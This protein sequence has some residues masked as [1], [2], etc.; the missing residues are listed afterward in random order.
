[1][2]FSPGSVRA[3]NRTLSEP[4][5]TYK[6]PIFVTQMMG[7][8]YD[9]YWQGAGGN[10]VSLRA[11]QSSALSIDGY[12]HLLRTR[13]VSSGSAGKVYPADGISYRIGQ[14]LDTVSFLP[15]YQMKARQIRYSFRCVPW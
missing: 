13:S 8:V 3:L 9:P 1:M 10:A 11:D 14:G 5:S 2:G 12:Q 4:G 15:H 7:I 6:D